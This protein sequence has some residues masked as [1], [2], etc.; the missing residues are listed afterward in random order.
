MI[1]RGQV[2]LLFE[3]EKQS[4]M[5]LPSWEALQLKFDCRTEQRWELELR[6]LDKIEDPGCLS[7]WCHNDDET[8]EVKKAWVDEAEAEGLVNG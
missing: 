4:L 5:C 1:E 8:L 6:N 2:A 7:R 3:S